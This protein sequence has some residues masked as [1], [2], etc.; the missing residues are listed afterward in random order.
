MT[1]T[2]VFAGRLAMRC[3]RK[4]KVKKNGGAPSLLTRQD[5]D[6]GEVA[7]IFSCV[8]FSSSFSSML[9]RLFVHL[10]TFL[11]FSFFYYIRVNRSLTF[12]G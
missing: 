11:F 4:R 8:F 3:T 5:D 7:V 1:K 9:V 12:G 10:V 2:L 6:V